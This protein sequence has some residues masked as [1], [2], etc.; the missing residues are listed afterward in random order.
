[1]GKGAIV[2][3]K[4]ENAVDTKTRVLL[5]IEKNTKYPFWRN[6]GVTVLG[7]IIGGMVS[8]LFLLIF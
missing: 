2:M 7:G 8:Q 4:V 1:M 5:G 3:P 6:L